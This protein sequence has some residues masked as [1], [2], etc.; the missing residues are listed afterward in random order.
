MRCADVNS[1]SGVAH[2]RVCARGAMNAVVGDPW[3][4]DRPWYVPMGPGRRLAPET[5]LW[6]EPA[7]RAAHAAV[8]VF[9]VGQ[10]VRRLRGQ[11]EIALDLPLERALEAP[12]LLERGRAADPW[13]RL[14]VS[15]A[16]AQLQLDGEPLAELTADGVA[17]WAPEPRSLAR[18]LWTRVRGIAVLEA[19]AVGCHCGALAA[20]QRGA[21][22]ACRCGTG[23]LFL[24]QESG[25]RTGAC[26]LSGLALEDPADRAVGLHGR[27]L[28]ECEEIFQPALTAAATAAAAAAATASGPRAPP[29]ST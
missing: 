14:V 9:A 23:A 17:W 27:V 1:D 12:L 4:P 8:R 28:G 15:R 19:L 11:E 20:L 10:A 18:A 3:A 2:L 6:A 29:R 22:A 5:A 25:R 21:R 7:P 26:G 24:L 13:A 16:R